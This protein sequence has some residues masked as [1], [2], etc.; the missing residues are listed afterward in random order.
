MTYTP[1]QIWYLC[2]VGLGHGLKIRG[3]GH[4]VSEQENFGKPTVNHLEFYNGIKVKV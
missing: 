3:G 2:L 4:E 1:Y